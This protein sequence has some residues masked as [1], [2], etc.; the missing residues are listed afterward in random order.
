MTE[1]EIKYMTDREGYEK[2]IAAL[3]ASCLKSFGRVQI[4]YYYDTDGRSLHKK[5]ITLRVR[6]CAGV[7]QGQIKRHDKGKTKNAEESYFAVEKLPKTIIFEGNSV[8]LLG[9][10]VTERTEFIIKEN[11]DRI[12]LKA[13]IDANHYLGNTDYEI[14]IEFPDGSE[15]RAEEFAASLGIAFLPPAGGKYSRFLKALK[16]SK[17]LTL[18]I[19]ENEAGSG[20]IEL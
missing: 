18:E 17:K 2:C 3:E 6:Q 15:S 16:S 11:G 13:D 1:R 7:L 9:S 12:G 4:N 8:K 10:L 19:K 20:T 5:G 14:E